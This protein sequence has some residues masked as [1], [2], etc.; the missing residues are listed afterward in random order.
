[1]NNVVRGGMIDSRL[2]GR[3]T[4]GLMRMNAKSSGREGLGEG[5][6]QNNATGDRQQTQAIDKHRNFLLVKIE[7]PGRES[8]LMDSA[9]SRSVEGD[10]VGAVLLRGAQFA[11]RA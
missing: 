7:P 3:P 6:V 11:G 5:Q 2:D 9:K 1:L 10:N 8:V 4:A